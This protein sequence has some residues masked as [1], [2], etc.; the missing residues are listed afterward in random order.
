MENNPSKKKKEE[1]IKRLLIE[2]MATHEALL[3]NFIESNLKKKKHCLS[4]YI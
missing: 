2:A 1:K 4:K 3:K